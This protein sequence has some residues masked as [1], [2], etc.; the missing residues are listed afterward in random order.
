MEL[1]EDQEK[2]QTKRKKGKERIKKGKFERKAEQMNKKRT[3]RK[4]IIILI[5]L[6]VEHIRQVFTDPN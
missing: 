5:G 3:K 6:I 2:Q 1:F 4:I